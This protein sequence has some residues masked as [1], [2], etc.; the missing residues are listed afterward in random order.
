MS[1]RGHKIYHMFTCIGDIAGAR[2]LGAS[3]IIGADLND[4]K[5]PKAEF[6]RLM[7]FS[8]TKELNG[9]AEKVREMT[10]GLGVDYRFECTGVESLVNEAVEC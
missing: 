3:R 10:G 7:D 1:V 2:S 6:F 5:K 8:D 9:I 4:C